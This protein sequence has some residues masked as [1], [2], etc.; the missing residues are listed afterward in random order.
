MNP[1]DSTWSGSSFD[2]VDRSGTQ[3]D[4]DSVLM[5]EA[6]KVPIVPCP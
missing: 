1:D 2:V 5:E 3:P 6:D 4:F